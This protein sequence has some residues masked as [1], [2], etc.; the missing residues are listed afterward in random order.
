MRCVKKSANI[1][2][3]TSSSS[4]DV[5]RHNHPLFGPNF[6]TRPSLGCAHFLHLRLYNDFDIIY[7]DIDTPPTIQYYP[8]LTLYEMSQQPL[9]TSEQ[10]YESLIKICHMRLKMTSAHAQWHMGCTHR[11]GDYKGWNGDRCY[12]PD[13]MI[14]IYMIYLGCEL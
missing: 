5:G 10:E 2:I 11:S 14:V 12:T 6:L 3:N 4:C 1:H 13:F 8:L 9:G 7:N